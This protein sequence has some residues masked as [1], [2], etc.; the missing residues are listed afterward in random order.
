M[1][2]LTK[3]QMTFLSWLAQGNYIDVCIELCP[4]LG[5]MTGFES[6]N[7]GDS[8]TC[9]GHFQKR[10]LFK[11]KAQ[12]YINESVHHITGIR[13][14]RCTLSQRGQTHA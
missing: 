4:D 14:L 11:L 12:G 5:K 13:Y 2:A 9:N 10:T 7:K 8:E 1:A 3:E 6:Y